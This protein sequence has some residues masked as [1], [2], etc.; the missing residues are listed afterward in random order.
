MFFPT[1]ESSR[2]RRTA[3]LCAGYVVLH[4][5]AH[6]SA[7]LF[8]VNPGVTVS[9]WY[10]PVGL[11]L[12]LMVMLG[13]RFA[14]L[15][16]LAN[17]A[18]AW[19]GPGDRLL[20]PNLFFPG[21]ITLC[22]GGAAWAVR[23]W[24]GPGLLPG[25]GRA[26]PV[27]CLVVAAVP[28]V[29]A[30]ISTT[31]I[32][33]TELG[34]HALTTEEF[35]RSAFDWWLGDASG[36]LVV[37]PAAM[38]FV[39]P[40]LEGKKRLGERRAPARREIVWALARWAVLTSSLLTV[41]CVPVLREHS[42]FYLCFLPLIWIAVRHGLPG[43]TLATVLTMV[44]GLAGMKLAGT[45]RDF[46]YIYLL[47]EAAVAVVGLGLGALVTGREEAERA[48][49]RHRERMDRVVDGA[50]LGV[51]EREV[52]TGRMEGNAR[53]TGMIG[54]RPEE[55]APLEKNLPALLH[56]EDRRAAG[57]AWRAHLE[58]RRDLFE[59]EV[60]IRAKDGHWRWVESR[61]SVVTRDERGRPLLVAGTQEDVTARKQAE[62]AAARLSGIVEAS[63][64]F[65]LTTDEAGRVLYANASLL[66]WSGRAPWPT[67]DDGPMLEELV[68]AET[69]ARWRAEAIPAALAEGAW[70]GEG[71]LVDGAGR[72]LATSQA[73]VATRDPATN[74]AA[75]SFVLRDISDQKRAEE[76][77]RQRDREL[78]Q[79]QKSE[80][81]GVLAGGIAHDF[82]NLLTAIVGNVNLARLGL[83]PGA[84]SLGY[85]DN[86]ERAAGRAARLCQQMLAYAG[87]NPVAFAE[88]DLG[89]LV[90]DV[91]RLIES[92][93]NPR[94]R[95]VVEDGGKAAPILA[96]DTQ[97]QQ[98][99]LNLV[100]NAAEAVGERGGEVAVRIRSEYLD[101]ERA[102]ELFPGR[103]PPPGPYTLLEV[104]DDGAGMTPEVRA[105]IFEPFFTTKFTGQGLGLAAVAG[106]VKSHRGH[107]AVES[108][109]GR[110]ALFRLA[111]PSVAARGETAGE[112]P[113][114][115]S[116]ARL[117]GLVLLV[118]DDMLIREVGAGILEAMGFRV[119][120]A[121]DGAEG[122]DCFRRHEGLIKAVL[123]D[124][125]MPRMDG[126]EAH[127][128]MHRINPRVPVVLMSGFSSKLEN[129][130]PEAIHPA[131]VLPKPFGMEQ[132]R[133]R[134]AAVMEN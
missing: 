11:A 133:E 94:V 120:L 47:F 128:E 98:V 100:I 46:S 36:L 38:V 58:G 89:P 32:H 92:S 107:I 60:R 27:F 53:L 64:D 61:G 34:G 57:E 121:A 41:V 83:A 81:L 63:P 127:A 45:T 95:V 85:L 101:T 118:D 48:L 104:E 131:G 119:L 111:F 6:L 21:L 37:V 1:V 3:A 39:A 13:P 87:R 23:R 28:L 66:S 105:R 51:W 62:Q 72:A 52:A 2:E 115:P 43:A 73:A 88:I 68:P 114:E 75:I 113:A 134:L 22:Y 67:E 59:T 97:M 35:L 55:L 69:A 103:A 18:T 42:A 124:L 129:L 123:L 77:R 108:A 50:R 29:P 102:A 122:V 65:I 56:P 33:A 25:A 112:E 93:I 10:P 8:E 19:I 74:E 90:R 86:V 79:L 7:F 96:A 82:N 5:M 125:T 49:V 80:S 116:V 9:I 109:P 71:E 84:R 4:V 130:P 12:A 54:Y 126:F 26:T 106:V 15:V 117:D 17:F 70:L 24:H 31:V 44:V 76:E 99:A 110:G 132:L 78:Q 30:L 16:F 40:W 20:W 91:W 14:W